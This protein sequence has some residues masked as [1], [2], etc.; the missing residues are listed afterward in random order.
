[1]K[2]KIIKKNDTKG[3]NKMPFTEEENKLR[4][5]RRDMTSIVS[6]WVDEFRRVRHEEAKQDLE[7]HFSSA[8]SLARSS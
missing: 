2:I 1:M 3:V 8:L 7:W 4:E 5:K 6:G